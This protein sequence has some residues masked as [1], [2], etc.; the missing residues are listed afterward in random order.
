MR[1]SRNCSRGSTKPSSA[2]G[3]KKSIPTRSI[4][5]SHPP[6]E[7]VLNAE[8]SLRQD[9]TAMALTLDQLRRLLHDLPLRGRRQRDSQII[10]QILQPIK[11]HATAI[12]QLCNHGGG[13][14][15]VLVFSHPFRD[16]RTINLST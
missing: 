15:L 12:F 4:L 9:G 10:F 5:L 6:S 1:P 8:G 11:R 16:V 13:A 3:Q 14:F 2:P 7:P